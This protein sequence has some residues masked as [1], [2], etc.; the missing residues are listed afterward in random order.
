MAK[1]NI[2]KRKKNHKNLVVFSG[3]VSL[4]VGVV[5]SFGYN[6]YVENNYN[7]EKL[8]KR[9]DKKIDLVGI[10]KSYH[11]FVKL[12]DGASIYVKKENGY[13][14]AS[15]AYGEIEISL[16]STY[17]VVD[18]YFKVLDSDYYVKY[19]EVSAIDRLSA[20][21]GEYKYYNNYIVYNEN[22][23]LKDGAKLYIS[24][25]NYYEVNGGSYPII[26]KDSDRYG[27][28]YNNSLVYV[29]S[30]D[31]KSLVESTNTYGWFGSFELSF[32]S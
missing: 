16:D 4:M 24:D 3:L 7:T 27:I 10:K 15:T 28:E 12:Q 18:K 21:K 5:V 29:N 23:V 20:K 8:V 22:V 11:D 9:D 26:I 2:R 30:N 17:E 19:N 31:I 14:V 13:E 1:K 25:N 6:Y 32:Y